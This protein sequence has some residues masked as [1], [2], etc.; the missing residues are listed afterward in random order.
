MCCALTISAALRGIMPSPMVIRPPKTAAG[1]LGRAMPSLLPSKKS[2]AAPRIIA[3]DLGFLT[4]D[5]RA[6][7]KECAYPGMKVL[8]FAF[9]SRDGGDYRP[10]SYPHQLHCLHWHP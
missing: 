7:L 5:V 8:E 10:H 3:E 1:A 4:D 9:D 2:W 6:L